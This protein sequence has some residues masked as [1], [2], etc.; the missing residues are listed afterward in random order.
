MC[1]IADAFDAKRRD[2]IK[3]I[4]AILKIKLPYFFR[5]IETGDGSYHILG[6]E[7]DYEDG[8]WMVGEAEDVN[9][10]GLF[11]GLHS[12]DPIRSVIYT[13]K[14]PVH[15]QR[16]IEAAQHEVVPGLEVMSVVTN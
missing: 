16:I 3:R 1:G 12:L 4:V 5:Y 15:A 11:L 7:C 14:C 2:E 10:G 13:D 8:V 6:P 9:M